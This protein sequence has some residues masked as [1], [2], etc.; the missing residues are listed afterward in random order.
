L[1]MTAGLR[2]RNQ[3]PLVEGHGK[4]TIKLDEEEQVNEER[5]K[6]EL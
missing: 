3:C 4:I 5:R 2:P 6:C 1:A